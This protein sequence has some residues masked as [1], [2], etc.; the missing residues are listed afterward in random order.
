MSES[1]LSQS[2]VYCGEQK[3]RVSVIKEGTLTVA[4]EQMGL[5]H[6]LV[7]QGM[8]VER[9]KTYHGKSSLTHISGGRKSL[10]GLR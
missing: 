7:E 4:F 5:V 3:C 10:T 2:K 6:C 9:L 1:G 8:V